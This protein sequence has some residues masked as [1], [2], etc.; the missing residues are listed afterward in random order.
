M[1]SPPVAGRL[2]AT[3][4]G[5]CARPSGPGSAIETRLARAKIGDVSDNREDLR[6]MSALGDLEAWADLH[7]AKLTRDI[8]TLREDCY[9]LPEA[10]VRADGDALVKRAAA[11]ATRKKVPKNDDVWGYLNA[12]R[13]KL[14]VLSKD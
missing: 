11:L 10:V 8:G 3:T 9:T 1:S 7:D 12:L 2:C 5:S 14:S 6:L 13:N 4:T